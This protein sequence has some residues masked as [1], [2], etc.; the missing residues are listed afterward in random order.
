[1]K[2]KR[3]SKNKKIRP[4]FFIFCEGETEEAYVNYLRSQY[5]LPIEIKVKKKGSDINERYINNVKNNHT[6]HK[7]DETFLFYDSDIPEIVKKLRQIRNVELLLSS[8]CFE[9]W[10]LLHYQAQTAELTS[11]QCISELERYIQ[12]YK[13][14]TF[15][16]S[17]KE[18]L[19]MNKNEAIKRSENLETSKN[20]STSIYILIKRL[21]TEI[22]S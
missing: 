2:T 17:L 19:S 11:A 6:R 18:I 15:N 9:I 4:T 5:R 14:G 8:P 22:R 16:A 21:D 12:D 1:M 13:K 10:Y 7:K 20:P 3:I